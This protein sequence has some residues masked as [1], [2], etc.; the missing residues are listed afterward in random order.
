MPNTY[1]T[2]MYHKD[3]QEN[4]KEFYCSR[5]T[6][7]MQVE[8]QCIWDIREKRNAQETKNCLDSGPLLLR[9]AI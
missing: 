9:Q 5:A 8:A 3:S 7:G 1:G 4:F 6:L 2:W